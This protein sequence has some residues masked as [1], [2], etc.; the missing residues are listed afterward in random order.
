M[1][2]KWSGFGN[3]ELATVVYMTMK[4]LPFL[5]T[6][7]FV[8]I[9]LL[10]V[11]ACSD[12]DETVA[13]GADDD[14]PVSQEPTDDE[15]Q[16]PPDGGDDELP[17]GSGPY[18]VGTLEIAVTHPDAETLSYTIS[19]LGDTATI[20]PPVDGL[21][22]QTACGALT[23]DAARTLLF[24]GPADDRVCTEIYGGPDEAAITGTLD[25]QPVDVVITRNNG[26]G[27]DDWDTTLAGILPTARGVTG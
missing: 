18:P 8:A 19:C 5:S 2:K 13:D 9:A 25:D 15:A 6:F 23:A 24:D 4:K 14:T 20:T 22:E 7:L 1:I 10:F 26:C 3:L 11:A 21:S 16:P 17:L 12:G 27:I